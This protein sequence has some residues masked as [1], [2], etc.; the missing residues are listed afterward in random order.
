MTR[1]ELSPPNL[2][3]LP[4]DRQERLAELLDGFLA[5]LE[6][7]KPLDFASLEPHDADLI[8][9]M[10]AYLKSLSFLHQ[11]VHEPAAGAKS[12]PAI[13]ALDE[14]RLGDYRLLREIGRGGM[15]VVYEAQQLSLGRRVAV[16]VLPFA[17]VLDDRQIARFQNE[18]LAAAQLHHP[19]IVPVYSV[20]CERGVHHYSMQLIEGQSLDRMLQ[21]LRVAGRMESP[22]TVRK[23]VWSSFRAT[24][25]SPEPLTDTLPLRSD[26]APSTERS[27]QSR[28]Y[29]RSIVQLGIQAAEALACAHDSGVIH[30]DIKPSNLLV[31]R[32]GKL[33]ITD[34]GLARCNSGMELTRVGELLGTM[35]Y[36]SPEQANGTPHRVDHRTDIYALGATLYELLTLRPVVDGSDRQQVLRQIECDR[37]VSP[38][39]LNRAVDVDLETILLKALAKSREDRYD[40]AADFAAD[41]RRVAEGKPALARRLGPLDYAARYAVRHARRVAAAAALLTL[42]FI[43]MT[44][45]AMIVVRQ[46]TELREARKRTDQHLQTARRVVER[47]QD[48]VAERLERV[49]GTDQVRAELLRDA[50]TYQRSYIALAAQD[51]ARFGE[52][53]EAYFDLARLYQRLGDTQPALDAYQHAQHWFSQTALP[54]AGPLPAHATRPALCHVN[55]GVLLVQLGR[56]REAANRYAEALRDLESLRKRWPNTESLERELAVAQLNLGRLHARTGE[57][58]AAR[59]HLQA[60]QSLLESI[61]DNAD[62]ADG[63]AIVNAD[64]NTNADANAD[65]RATRL[66]LAAVHNAFAG[67]S[68]APPETRRERLVAAC[69][70]YRTLLDQSPNDLESLQLAGLTLNHL[71]TVDRAAFTNSGHDSDRGHDSDGGHDSDPS[72]RE[73]TERVT[74]GYRQAIELQARLVRQAP[75]VLGYRS[76][77]AATWNNLGQWYCELDELPAAE[78]ALGEARGLLEVICADHPNRVAQRSNLGGVLHNLAIV[79]ERQ[80]RWEQARAALELAIRHQ[81]AAVTAAPEVARFREFLEEHHAQRMRLNHHTPRPS[82][83][84]HPEVSQPSAHI[85]LA[86]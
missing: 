83:T 41:L 39:S 54:P 61:A 17:A 8:V 86:P 51:P 24:A 38:R 10:R 53:G 5:E 52:L 43:A 84:V 3:A 14:Q 78:Q 36:M 77:L 79:M 82:A 64:A 76:E 37:P 59:R 6:Q 42:T 75:L 34:F 68:D 85:S 71:A 20:G 18:A 46:N 30:R 72:R 74:R 27:V 7:G 26:K 63:S 29:V 28:S 67:L 2:D 25:A 16:K 13:E 19:N 45:T 33:W 47:F 21:E 56:Y 9:P 49:P 81:Q 55:C 65:P 50:V 73:L 1:S 62:D 4:A 69:Q 60:A 35:R 31:D 44:V 70:L 11:A 15:G 23:R 57:V 32:H 12:T 22:T 66:Q 58:A 48:D 40:S 80:Q